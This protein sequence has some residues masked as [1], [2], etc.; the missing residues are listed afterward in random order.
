[1]STT[2]REPDDWQVGDRAYVHDPD[3]DW[4]TGDIFTVRRLEDPFI[5]KG[6][7]NVRAQNGIRAGRC[8][9]IL[10][11][12]EVRAL[13]PGDRVLDLRYTATGS[14]FKPREMQVETDIGI[15][16]TTEDYKYERFALISLAPREPSKQQQALDDLEAAREAL[17]RAELRVREMS[18]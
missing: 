1:M 6:D 14:S 15:Q 11:V 3:D 18:T 12:D 5:Y 4:S 9:R 2:I 16:L 10:T 17:A 7:D 13:K 8:Y